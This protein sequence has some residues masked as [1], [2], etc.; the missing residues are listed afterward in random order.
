MTPMQKDLVRYILNG[1]VS[2]CIIVLV[3]LAFA[4]M[5]ADPV[6]SDPFDPIEPAKPECHAC[7]CVVEAETFN[8]TGTVL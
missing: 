5:V 1:L 6:R 3:S 7:G 4:V 8:F 2:I